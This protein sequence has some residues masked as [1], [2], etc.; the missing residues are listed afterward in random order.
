MSTQG[1]GA[2]TEKICR[3]PDPF[4]PGQNVTKRVKVKGENLPADN[5]EVPLGPPSGRMNIVRSSLENRMDVGCAV[6]FRLHVHDLC[7]VSNKNIRGLACA[8]TSR[9][10]SLS[11]L[12]S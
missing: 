7:K 3:L 8:R 6:P 4:L 11:A 12:V 5:T 10:A 2:S 1:G 9:L